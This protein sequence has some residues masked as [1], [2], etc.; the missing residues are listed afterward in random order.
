[1]ATFA[2]LLADV[3]L[4][5][6]RPDLVNETK[7]AVKAATLKAHQ[8][9]FYYKDLFET[10]IEFNTSDYVQALEYREVLPRFRSLKYIR[11]SDSTGT[12]GD[13][14]SVIT[15][16]L[17]LDRYGAARED[18]CYGAGEVI[19]IKSSTSLQYILLG[20]YLN[21]NIGEDTYSSWIALDHPYYIVYEA[22]A[23]VFKLTGDDE[24]ATVYK[25]F[26]DEQI[27]LLKASNIEL[28]GV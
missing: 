6:N 21:P 26:T 16:A 25:R 2:E 14:L 1:M 9:D 17:A 11:K 28:E 12:V 4:L 13:F 22:A 18:I 20:C 19:Q 24:K 5:T 3:Y 7:L 10:G 15:P 8:S 27:A 23:S